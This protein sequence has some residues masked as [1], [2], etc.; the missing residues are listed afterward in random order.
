MKTITARDQAHLDTGNLT[1]ATLWKITRRDGQVFT[2]TDHDQDIEFGGLTYDANTSYNRTATADNSQLSPSNMVIESVLDDTTIT[3]D[4]II[5]GLW[6]YAQV[7]MR[8]VNWHDRRVLHISNVTK[9]NPGVVTTREEHGLSTGDTVTI[10]GVGGMTQLNGN[11]YTVTV[12]S[13]T[14]FSIGT[15]TSGY[16]TYLAL[17]E[18]RIPETSWNYRKG[19]IGQVETDSN[20]FRSELMGFGKQLE[21]N[22]LRIYTPSC[23]ALLGDTECGVSLASFTHT[24][25]IDSVDSTGLEITDAERAEAAGYFDYGLITMTS[26]ASN[27]YS[28]EVKSNTV[29]VIVLQQPLPF[30]VAAGDTYSIRAGCDKTRETCRDK[31]NNVVNFR[32]FPDLPGMDKVLQYA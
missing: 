26:G 2:F 4:D 16:G 32:G 18:C 28:M 14:T 19:R 12:I 20:G 24:G 29:G 21:K 13:S 3:E 11:T 30:G 9:A 22:L 15:N 8:T 5:A 7:E 6:D 17:G 31:F 23:P 25:T 10:S 27:G 1:T